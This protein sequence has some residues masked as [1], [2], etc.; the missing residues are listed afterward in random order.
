[1]TCWYQVIHPFTVFGK[2]VS[3]L[4]AVLHLMPLRPQWWKQLLMLYSPAW[5]W[6]TWIMSILSSNGYQKSR[7]MEAAFIQ[8]RYYVFVLYHS[9]TCFLFSAPHFPHSALYV[10][11]HQMSSVEGSLERS[12]RGRNILSELQSDTQWQ[13]QDQHSCLLSLSP[14]LSFHDSYWPWKSKKTTSNFIMFCVI[15]VAM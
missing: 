7:D 11:V 3:N 10:L 13:S 6:K 8:P 14:V 5:T 12:C 9:S 4:K 15:V 1:M 2:T